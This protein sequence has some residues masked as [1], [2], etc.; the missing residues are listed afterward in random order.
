MTEWLM[1]WTFES[2]SA[3]PEVDFRGLILM[4]PHDRAFL[5]LP[6]RWLL[7]LIITYWYWELEVSTSFLPEQPHFSPLPS[8]CLQTRPVGNSSP[9]F[10]FF[11]SWEIWHGLDVICVIG[12]FLDCQF[13]P[14]SHLL[15]ITWM[16]HREYKSQHII[17]HKLTLTVLGLY[18]SISHSVEG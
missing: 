18:R 1:L 5:S 11:S 7:S 12:N 2:C 3:L 8:F 4:E 14:T 10:W 9:T 15:P 17:C 6:G 16:L 13:P